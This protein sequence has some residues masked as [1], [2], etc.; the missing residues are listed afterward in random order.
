MLPISEGK[1]SKLT[2]FLTLVNNVVAAIW[3]TY[4]YALDKGLISKY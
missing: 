2:I 3:F 1:F 4:K